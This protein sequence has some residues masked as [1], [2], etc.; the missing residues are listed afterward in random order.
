MALL[1]QIS[2]LGETVLDVDM[3]MPRLDEI[4]LHFVNGEQP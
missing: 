1:R 4:Y 3:T 2:L